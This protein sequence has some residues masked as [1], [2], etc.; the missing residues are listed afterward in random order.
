MLNVAAA[1]SLNDGGLSDLLDSAACQ[2]VMFDDRHPRRLFLG[3]D[4]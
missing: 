2:E 4:R 1:V 3:P